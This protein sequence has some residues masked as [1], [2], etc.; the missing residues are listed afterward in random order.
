[1]N[2]RYE[3]SSIDINI[4]T[5][6]KKYGCHI[7]GIHQHSLHLRLGNKIITVGH[8]ISEG[9]HH[10]VTHHE[11]DF[12][13]HD[14]SKDQHVY[15]YDNFLKVGPLIFEIKTSAIKSYKPYVIK[16]DDKD[17]EV[18]TKRL[19]DL[20]EHRLSTD[21]LAKYNQI[22]FQLILE[23]IDQFIKTQDFNHAKKLVGLGPG[24]TPY[25]DDVLVGY[26][27]GKNVRGHQI[28]WLNELLDLVDTKTNML[29]AQNIKDTYEK[30]YPQLYV[31]MIEDIFIH[32]QQN[33]AEKLMDVGDTSGI[34]MLYGFLH[35]IKEGEEQYESL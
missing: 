9:I 6:I 34:G 31:A 23:Y 25:G 32:K 21:I 3:I 28:D 19:L 11:V 18:L 13:A 22:V 5:L 12:K 10:I 7:Y 20:I 33:Y 8:H 4:W 35:G 24:L 2:H 15:I 1:M 16:Y 30:M 14:L 27:M 26:I 17:V 29:S